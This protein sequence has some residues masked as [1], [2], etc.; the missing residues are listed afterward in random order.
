MLDERLI[1]TTFTLKDEARSGVVTLY[2]IL[3]HFTVSGA[4]APG[5]LVVV[6]QATPLGLIVRRADAH[7]EF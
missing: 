2:G 7:L 4:A 5:D 1:G 6:E 3:Y